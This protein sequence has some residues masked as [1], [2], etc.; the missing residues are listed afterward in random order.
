MTLAIGDGGNDVPMIQQAHIGV[1]I[2][3]KEG[4]QASRAADYSISHFSALQ[5]LVLVHGRYSYLRTALVAQYSFYK[6]FL[7]C[8]VQIMFGFVSYFSGSTLFNSLCIT[9]Y[10][11][12]LFVP[13]VSFVL[14]KDVSFDTTL[15]VLSPYSPL[16][17]SLLRV[18]PNEDSAQ[19]AALYRDGVNE[20]FF[21]A[22]T[23][24]FWNLRGLC[25]AI[26]IFVVTVFTRNSAYHLIDSGDAADYETMGIVAFCAYLWVQAVTMTLE[27]RNVTWINVVAIWGMH[28]LT[29]AILLFTSAI[30]EF[31]TINGFNIVLHAFGDLQFWLSNALMLA[32]CTVPVVF[33]ESYRRNRHPTLVDH[34]RFLEH[35]SATTRVSI[36]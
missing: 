17:R 35:K 4:L 19:L 1:G 14:D 23:M 6:S 11:A 3:G 31:D 18:L 2:R 13:I 12:V 27:L 9:V 30:V 22:R 29:F 7:F 15:A 5:R 20:V 10:N 8:C 26:V 21:N 25:Q 33:M 24:F 34:L 28:A 16:R 32:A 36:C